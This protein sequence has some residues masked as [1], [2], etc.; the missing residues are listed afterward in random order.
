MPSPTRLR[1]DGAE[2][3]AVIYLRG[4]RW[5]V[6]ATNVLYRVGELDVVADDGE[7]LVFVEVRSG[8]GRSAVPAAHTVTLPKQR[9]LSR[10]AGLFLAHYSGPRFIARFDVLGVDLDR[11]EVVEHHF[12]AF[13]ATE[14]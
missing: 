6:L 12:G 5:Q 11:L 10:A 8:R 14:F 1:G 3:A 7:S 9:R 4:L 2:R 13:D